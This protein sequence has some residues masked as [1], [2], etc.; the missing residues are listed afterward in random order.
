MLAGN[1]DREVYA[2]VRW[3]QEGFTAETL[4]SHSGQILCET[5]W[6]YLEKSELQAQ[7]SELQAE[8]SELRAGRPPESEPDH[9]ESI[10]EWG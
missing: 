1:P 2:Y 3:I 8:K 9:P 10:P 6:V 7:K 4:R 5:I